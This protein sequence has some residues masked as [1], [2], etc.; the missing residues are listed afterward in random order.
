MAAGNFRWANNAT[1]T[2]A[3]IVAEQ[4]EGA[5]GYNRAAF[6]TDGT[7]KPEVLDLSEPAIENCAMCHGFT[8]RN[9]TTIQPIQFADIARGTEKAGWIYNGAKISDTVAPKIVG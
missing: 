5:F 6:N 7:V 3:G 1:L 9:T 8:A 4:E 2:G